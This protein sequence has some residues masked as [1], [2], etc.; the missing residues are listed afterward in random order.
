[1]EP[2][3]YPVFPAHPAQETGISLQ[4][5]GAEKHGRS[6]S[7]GLTTGFYFRGDAPVG[8]ITKD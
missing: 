2:S 3:S 4:G 6:V 7:Q 1:M 5:E 8:S